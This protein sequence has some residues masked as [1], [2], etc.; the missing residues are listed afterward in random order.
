M[1][2]LLW[3]AGRLPRQRH[4][5]KGRLLYKRWDIILDKRIGGPAWPGVK[6]EVGMKVGSFFTLGMLF[7]AL[8]L[9]PIF[10]SYPMH[11][12]TTWVVNNIGDTT[13]GVCNQS[14]CSLPDAIAFAAAS[15]DTITFSVTGTIY[16]NHYGMTIGKDLTISGPGAG[17][18]SITGTGRYTVFHIL[19]GKTV[20]ISGLTI[21]HGSSSNGGGIYN[22]GLLTLSQCTVSD[23]TVTGN[24]GG[25]YN[26]GTATVSR[27]T[28]IINKAN[29]GGG[30]ENAGG[31]LSVTNSTFTG[32]S[33]VNKGGGI[34]NNSNST[35]NVTNSTFRDNSATTGGGIATISSGSIAKN[36]LMAGNYGWNCNG[37][38]VAGST[39]NLATDNKCSP[40]FTQVSLEQLALQGLIGNPGYFSL[41]PGS[42]AIDAGTNDGCPALDE[43]GHLRPQDGDGNGV[44]VCDVGAFEAWPLTLYLPLVI[45]N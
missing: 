34:D 17:I 1:P 16:L 9:G 42:A 31:A 27:S 12:A 41:W 23:H 28:F 2:V 15:G 29:N 3:V 38:F 8:A 36:I 37:Q 45:G 32:N 33:A 25:L 43:P 5:P 14:M 22:E 7:M 18:L 19:A 21:T 39:N 10:S 24:G 4:S 30:I 40:G 13:M 11:T 6:R 26:V 35:L 44:A 20:T